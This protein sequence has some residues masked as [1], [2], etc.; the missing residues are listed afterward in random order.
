MN[1][2]RNASEN[3]DIS[4]TEIDY[5]I[6]FIIN[7]LKNAGVQFNREELP[8]IFFKRV[9]IAIEKGRIRP[10]LNLFYSELAPNWEQPEDVDIDEMIEEGVEKFERALEN[11]IQKEEQRKIR[12]RNREKKYKDILHT[13]RRT[14]LPDNVIHTVA[15]FST[16]LKRRNMNKPR[17]MNKTRKNKNI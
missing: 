3:V 12:Q 8:I 13:M 11:R 7:P 15:E 9:K 10:V 14:V 6:R 17:N 4:I 5:M 16:G 2:L 1:Y